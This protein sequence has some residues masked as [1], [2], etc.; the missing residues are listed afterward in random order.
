MGLNTFFPKQAVRLH[1][2]DKPWI[3][4]DIKLL[5]SHRQQALAMGNTIKYN[6]L[7]NEVIRVVKLAKSKYFQ[8]QVNHL[9]KSKPRK[10]WSAIKNLA[11]YSLKSDIHSVE[12]DGNILQ[13]RD[14]AVAINKVFLASNE[15]MPPL[16]DADKLPIEETTAPYY[17]SVIDVESC[18]RAVKIA[19]APGP[20]PLPSWIL[21]S[22]SMELSEPVTALFNASFCQAQVPN[23][24]EEENVIHIP[25]KSPVTDINSYLRPISLTT[26]LSKIPRVLSC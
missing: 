6:K 10:W 17:I 4:S 20:D 8:S 14:L 19:K 7:R 11:G 12:V 23:Q 15:S 16:S 18:L 13:G 5:I 9:K 3:T 1:C 25:N 2:R 22:F 24:W 21:H 26:T